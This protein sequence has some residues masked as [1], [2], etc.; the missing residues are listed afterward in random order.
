MDGRPKSRTTARTVGEL[1]NVEQDQS[2]MPD[3]EQLQTARERQRAI[4]LELRRMY[5]GIV[6]EP[7]PEDFY[8]LLWK[9]DGPKTDGKSEK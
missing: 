1:Q 8:D 9:I 7:V 4:G 6:N 2:A 5:N 3:K